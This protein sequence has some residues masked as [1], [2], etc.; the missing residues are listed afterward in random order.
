[1]GSTTRPD[2]MIPRWM[3]FVRHLIRLVR[4]TRLRL[5]SFGKVTFGDD[6]ATGRRVTVLS[7]Q[8]FQAGDRVHIGQDFLCEVDAKIGDDVLISSFV[9]MIGNDH[10]FD[11][12]GNTVFGAGRTS[13]Q[14]QVLEGDN[15]IGNGVIIV[16]DVRVGRGAIVG[17]GS[18]VTRD[19]PANWICVGRPASPLRP[20]FQDAEQ[21][22]AAMPLDVRSDALAASRESD[23]VG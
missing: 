3:R 6:F 2:R 18:L 9:R 20:R 21:S 11:V 19:L 1:M 15:L 7:P 12:N 23:A 13:P 14:C 4:R 17:A 8:Y 16:G 10:S 22:C 5:E